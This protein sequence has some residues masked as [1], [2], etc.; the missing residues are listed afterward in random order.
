MRGGL[1]HEGLDPIEARRKL[2]AEGSVDAAKTMTFKVCAESLHRR[3]QGRLEEPEACSTIGRRRCLLMCI[4]CLARL[5][6]QAGRCR[7]GDEGY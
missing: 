5:P 4:R 1:R 3:A 2:L 7:P 6:A